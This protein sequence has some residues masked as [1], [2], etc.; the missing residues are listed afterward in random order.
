[1]QC[2]HF[3]VEPAKAL[4]AKLKVSEYKASLFFFFLL[5]QARKASS[6]FFVDTLAFHHRSRTNT[7][8]RRRSPW[9]R[10][11]CL[12]QNWLKTSVEFA[13][14]RISL[15]LFQN[16]PLSRETFS[17]VTNLGLSP[18]SLPQ[19][20]EVLEHIWKQDDIWPTPLC[21]AFL[22]QW[23]SVLESKVL[24]RGQRLEEKKLKYGSLRRE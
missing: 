22:L 15:P 6:P 13:R 12:S 2:F 18:A 19:R 3:L 1:M 23:T 10:I 8:G 5:P 24:L 4:T 16:S 14:C 21:Q 7:S 17:I 9:T 11:N 20:S